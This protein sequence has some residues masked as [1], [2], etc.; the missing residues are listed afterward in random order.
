MRQYIFSIYARGMDGTVVH[1]VGILGGKDAEQ[2]A[3]LFA[4]RRWS[5]LIGWYDHSA[6]VMETNSVSEIFREKEAVVSGN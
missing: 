3:I 5:P 6:S 4:K 1:T 2:E